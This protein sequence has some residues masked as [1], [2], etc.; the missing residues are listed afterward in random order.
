M[1]RLVITR[2]TQAGNFYLPEVD[3]GLNCTGTLGS[4]SLLVEMWCPIGSSRSSI[5]IIWFGVL[6]CRYVSGDVG[7]CPAGA[8]LAR[9]RAAT[10]T[11][12]GSS[13]ETTSQGGSALGE[14]V[15]MPVEILYVTLTS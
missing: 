10:R 2:Q 4:L 14:K 11:G 1:L 5:Q 13:M 7:F 15:L 9:G 12:K 3:G 6:S 8:W